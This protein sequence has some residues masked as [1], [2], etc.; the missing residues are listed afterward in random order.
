MDEPTDNCPECDARLSPTNLRCPACGHDVS[1]LIETR[2][3]PEPGPTAQ[4]GPERIGDFRIIRRI[5]QGGMASVFEAHQ[6]SMR[7]SVALKVLDTGYSLSGGDAARFEREAWIGGRLSHPNIVGVYDQ[8]AD[9]TAHYIAMQFVDGGSLL[10]FIRETRERRKKQ[11]GSDSAWRTDYVGRIVRLFVEVADALQ[12]VHEMGIVH[13]DIKPGNLLLTRDH[14]RML[15]SDFGLARDTETSRMTRRGDLLGTIRYMSPEQLLAQR[16]TVDHRTDIYSLGVSLYEAVTLDLP[17]S[18]DSAE[19]YMSAVSTKEPVP[20]RKRNR[21][22]PKD[23]ETVLIKCLERDPSRR[24][25]SAAELKQDLLRYLEDRPVIA[26]RPGAALK[27]VRFV[28]RHRMALGGLALTAM[29]GAGALGLWTRAA[30]E[31]RDMERIRWTL[32]QV[33]DTGSEPQELEP[34]WERLQEKLQAAVRA[35]PGG[36]LALTAMH[37]ACGAEAAIPAAF[38]LRSVGS[39]IQMFSSKA[40]NPGIDFTCL[41]ESEIAWD[42]GPWRPSMWTRL[43]FNSRDFSRFGFGSNPRL[44]R[45]TVGEQFTSGPHR[46]EIRLKTTLFDGINPSVNDWSAVASAVEVPADL[47]SQ[48]PRGQFSKR[49]GSYSVS[50]FDEYPPDFPKRIAAEDIT[51]MDAWFRLDRIRLVQFRVPPKAGSCLELAVPDGGGNLL[52]QIDAPTDAAGRLERLEMTGLFNPQT[53]FPIAAEA[54]LYLE[55][56]PEPIARFSLSLGGGRIST[57]F[58]V[59]RSIGGTKV[60]GE[61]WIYLQ[62]WRSVLLPDGNRRG[63][64]DLV[65]SR[66]VALKSGH[67]DRFI[68]RKLSL[69]VQ[70]EVNTFEAKWTEK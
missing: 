15:L 61:E 48:S 17:Y 37:A 16:V 58:E 5:G 2:P 65:P 60:S 31:R 54:T 6:E 56:L 36:G 3:F 52:C 26:R 27:T 38:A 11:P 43:H 59:W 21:A 9:G 10:D 53:S 51:G 44:D 70:I 1:S 14:A 40:F 68:D 18:G 25:P 28:K 29:L 33:I 35:D 55:A 42:G 19:A 39:E 69:P 34:D 12:H 62:K 41:L 20:A 63:R 23:L 50:L 7:R 32:D 30:Q 64:L 4:A 24:Y 13:R 49:L 22:V 67:V 66:D 8:G 57:Q 47:R 46:V 45:K